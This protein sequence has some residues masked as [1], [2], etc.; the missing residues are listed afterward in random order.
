MGLAALCCAA[1]AG[2]LLGAHTTASIGGADMPVVITLLN[3]YSGCACWLVVPAQTLSDCSVQG[4]VGL[5]P[6]RAVRAPWPHS[7]AVKVKSEQRSFLGRTMNS[8]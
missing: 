2:G 8:R 1:G 3:S 4:S 5:L 7:S 6:L